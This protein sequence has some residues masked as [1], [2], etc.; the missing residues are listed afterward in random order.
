MRPPAKYSGADASMWRDGYNHAERDLTT[1]TD[2]HAP[3][4]RK[5]YGEFMLGTL[6]REVPRPGDH[7]R[8]LFHEGY[9]ARMKEAV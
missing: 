2:E 6:N 1:A 4:R 8:R 5:H 9:A 3:A 7:I